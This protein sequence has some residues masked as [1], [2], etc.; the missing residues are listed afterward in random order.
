MGERGALTFLGR[1]SHNGEIKSFNLADQVIC[2][3]LISLH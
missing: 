1:I 2:G 3:L